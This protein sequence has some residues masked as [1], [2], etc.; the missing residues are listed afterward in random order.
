MYWLLRHSPYLSRAHSLQLP[1]ST[2][3]TWQAGL[4]GSSGT[5]S[6][7][8][9]LAILSWNHRMN[10]CKFLGHTFPCDLEQVISNLW[11]SLYAFVKEGSWTKID[12]QIPINALFWVDRWLEQIIQPLCACFSHT[13]KNNNITNHLLG[14]G[15]DATWQRNLPIPALAPGRPLLYSVPLP[16]S[17]GALEPERPAGSRLPVPR[18]LRGQTE[19]NGGV[20]GAGHGGR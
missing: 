4:S 17:A 3:P 11:V 14:Y 9:F 18:G 1:L 13:Q 12:F 16:F 10:G 6:D 7:P 19:T 8:Q 5:S 15:D 20:H 2:W